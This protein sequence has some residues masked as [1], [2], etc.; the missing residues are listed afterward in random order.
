MSQGVVIRHIFGTTRMILPEFPVVSVFRYAS[1]KNSISKPFGKNID[2]TKDLGHTTVMVQDRLDIQEVPTIV[3]K[4][5][6]VD[7]VGHS[8][9][10]KDI[11][12]TVAT[13]ESQGELAEEQT[14]LDGLQRCHDL[15]E[16][17]G[18]INVLHDGELSS[19]IVLHAL[20]R[21]IEL[22]NNVT[23]RNMLRSTGSS[24]SVKRT[25]TLDRLMNF[26]V[27]NVQSSV[28]LN[29]LNIVSRDTIGAR[30]ASYKK[31]LINEV[32]IRAN[33]RK[34]TVHQMCEIVNILSTMKCE[35]KQEVIDELWSGLI[36]RGREINEN[37][38]GEVFQT[39]PHLKQ[40]R[41]MIF[42]MLTRKCDDL[43]WR[44][45]PS[46]VIEILTSLQQIQINSVPTL[47]LMARNT[48][49]NINTLSE[50]DVLQ[51]VTCFS[52]C[53]YVDDYIEGFL[54]KYLKTKGPKVKSTLLLSAVMEYCVKYRLRFPA[55]LDVFA[56]YIISN[57]SN[58]SPVHFKSFL[59]PLGY[60][61]HTPSNRMKFWQTVENFMMEK[62]IQFRPEDIVDVVL[63]C[64]YL[65]KFPVNL[66]KKILNPYFLDRMHTCRS[67]IELQQLRTKLKI[68]DAA[69]TLE[70]PQY[71][72]PLLPRDY[73]VK[74]LP[75]DGRLKRIVKQVYDVIAD[76]VE[77]CHR[78]STGVLLPQL[79]AA[80]LYLVD[81]LL[82]PEGMETSLHTFDFSKDRDLCIAVLIHLPE[83]YCSKGVHLNGPQLMKKRH[84][85]RLGISVVGLK[86]SELVMLKG[87][88]ED[89]QNY[90]TEKI[91]KLEKSTP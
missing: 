81:I 57:A 35:S 30:D 17:Y 10:D 43:W 23:F 56:D 8:I 1:K 16:L 65:E 39:L 74:T 46:S 77:S 49:T 36:D 50:D 55:V 91:E 26:V 32:L 75:Q 40:S 71:Q 3:R 19:S 64:V 42:N 85:K 34:F 47:R 80:D 53:D 79:P 66:T 88:R 21:I 2:K 72:G 5:K 52:A 14:L 15:K 60:F 76:L 62:F 20:E 38:I 58:L 83:H 82:H 44:L 9:Q 89:L 25:N 51:I 69:M 70:C 12:L 33:D 31:K 6:T 63:S 27:S 48:S 41:K 86:Y 29:S 37:N 45:H 24:L 13:K 84:L 67:G 18:M 7:V 22:E 68:F 11:H 28:I 59:M 4:V 73:A 54:E 87:K 78:V 90:L 61:S